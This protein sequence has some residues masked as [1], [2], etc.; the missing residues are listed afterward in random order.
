MANGSSGG[1]DMAEIKKEAAK[2]TKK[3]NE[4]NEKLENLESQ[5]KILLYGGAAVLAINF[6]LLV[7]FMFFS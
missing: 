4:A 2:V 6:L 5:V 3:I 1:G 7:L